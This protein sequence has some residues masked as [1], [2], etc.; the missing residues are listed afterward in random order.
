VYMLPE[1]TR[2]SGIAKLLIS[3]HAVETRFLPAWITDDSVPH[4][5][6]ASNPHFDMTHQFLEDSSR[7]AGLAT[8]FETR[9][10]EILIS[11]G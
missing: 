6:G 2:M 5:V 4:V 3:E 1:N 9:G 7:D 8:R 10:D 11:A